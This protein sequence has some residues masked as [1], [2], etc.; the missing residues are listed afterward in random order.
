MKDLSIKST[1]KDLLKDK[2]SKAILKR[3]FGDLLKNPIIKRHNDKKLKEIYISLPAK[4]SKELIEKIDREL[5]L[6]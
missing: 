4:I 3:Y 5:K 6:L 2:E 1:L